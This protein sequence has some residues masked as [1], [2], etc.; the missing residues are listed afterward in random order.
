MNMM[1]FINDTL[2]PFFIMMLFLW[3]LRGLERFLK[4]LSVRTIRWM[5]APE[6]SATMRVE[7]DALS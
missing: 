2:F 5:I 7:W 4:C 6:N 1:R 3:H